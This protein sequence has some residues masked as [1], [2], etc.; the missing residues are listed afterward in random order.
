M[1]TPEPPD[2]PTPPSFDKD[3]PGAGGSA[4]GGSP[5]DTPSAD[6]YAS[7]YGSPYAAPG[8]GGAQPYGGVPGPA[9]TIVGMPPLAALG[10]R[11]VA[12]IID[13]LILLVIAVPLAIVAAV[14]NGNDHQALSVVAQVVTLFAAFL[15]EGL[16]L[17]H[18][19]G[20]TVGKKVMRI[21]VANLADG[22]APTNQSGWTR[23][24]VWDLPAIL[25]CGWQIVDALW[26][27]WDQPYRQC[28][29]D[30]AA[31]TVVVQVV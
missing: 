18:A 28:I 20:Q 22:S 5:Y 26:C 10:K 21:R 24:A 14:A 1:T 4:Q 12:R 17:T 29:H 8:P 30:K 6:P 11:L 9:D 27:T 2:E 13:W 3:R 31:K 19:G 25:C 15:Y 7:P 16:M 23:A